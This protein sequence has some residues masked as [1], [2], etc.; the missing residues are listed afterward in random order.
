[1]AKKIVDLIYLDPP[2][3]DKSA[4]SKINKKIDSW[5]AK[6]KSLQETYFEQHFDSGAPDVLEIMD[7]RKF[8]KR[9]LAQRVYW[10]EHNVQNATLKKKYLKVLP[11]FTQKGGL[12]TLLMHFYQVKE[13]EDKKSIIYDPQNENDKELRILWD[14]YKLRKTVASINT[15]KKAL[16]DPDLFPSIFNKEQRLKCLEALKTVFNLLFQMC[17]QKPYQKELYTELSGKYLKPEEIVSRWDRKVSF[18]YPHVVRKFDYRNHFFYVY[19]YSGMRAKIG[20]KMKEF[21]Y[22]YLDFEIIKQEFLI[23]WLNTKLGGNQRKVEIYSKYSMNDKTL[24]QIIA[25]DPSREIEILQQLPLNVFNDITSEINTQV[26]D[27]L[28]TEV[29]PLSEVHGDFAEV[30]KNYDTSHRLLK[31][32][33]QKLKLFIGKKKQP[34]SEIETPTFIEKLVK[35]EPFSEPTPIVDMTP[36][37]EIF[38]IKKNQIDYPYFKKE[39]TGYKQKLSLLRVKLGTDFTPFNSRLSKFLN[40]V[41]ESAF[42]TRRTPKHEWAC[43][44]HIKETIG[45]KATHHLLILGA[46]VK[47][48]QLSM[49]YSEGAS[50]K[51]YAYTC[52]FVYGC[53]ENNPIMGEVLDKRNARGV[54]FNEFDFINPEVQKTTLMLFDKVMAKEKM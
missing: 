17:I 8:L 36:K 24:D 48:K 25:E 42:I 26:D 1:M 49:G 3:D 29:D 31:S 47:A 9:F 34:E 28:K 45:E 50:Q 54:E 2:L 41:S 15:V 27:E 14:I 40:A 18:V 12:K 35:S 21:H 30:K 19:F 32:S 6:L 46:E 5:G 39:T 16:D 20:G 4:A 22:N 52:F 44:Y 23:N 33:M 51:A 7:M 37:Y 53:N 43:P 11:P 38:K 13:S 10:I